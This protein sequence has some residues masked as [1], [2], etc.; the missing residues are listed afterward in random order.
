MT[1]TTTS[2]GELRDN[3]LSANSSGIGAEHYRQLVLI[4]LNGHC[5]VLCLNGYNPHQLGEYLKELRECIKVDDYDALVSE[6]IQYCFNEVQQNAADTAVIEEV[7][8]EPQVN[9]TEITGDI[10]KDATAL[11]KRVQ[12]SGGNLALV[13]DTLAEAY[14]YNAAALKHF[15]KEVASGN[16]DTNKAAALSKLTSA[17]TKQ[18]GLSKMMKESSVQSTEVQLPKER[19]LTVL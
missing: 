9:G 8:A 19:K 7:D 5:R 3:I 16:V 18:M 15:N 14:C 6:V 4:H 10:I 12:T 2:L 1:D 17:L 13:D 11:I